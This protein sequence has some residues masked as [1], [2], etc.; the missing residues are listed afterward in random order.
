MGRD[1]PQKWNPLG[2]V[3]NWREK[4]GNM[5]KSLIT[6]LLIVMM[7]VSLAPVQAQTSGWGW[8]K[9]TDPND[10]INFLNGKAPYKQ[11][12]TK[13]EISAV[14]KGTYLEF[15]VFYQAGGPASTAGP[16]GWKKATDPND[17][18]NFLNGE[19]A[20]KRPVKEAKVAGVWKKTY[21]EYYVFYIP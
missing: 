16:W 11:K 13:A 12:I 15:I 2:S 18:K 4:G 3:S 10:V 14:N 6:L 8:K 20:Y 1:K 9:A 19:G 7:A 21:T 17:V 5:C